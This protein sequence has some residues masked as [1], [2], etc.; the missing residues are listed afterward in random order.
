MKDVH[1]KLIQDS[2]AKGGIQQEEA[3]AQ[4]YDL[5]VKERLFVYYVWN[6]ALCAAEIWTLRKVDAK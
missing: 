4:A 2:Q 5:N 3:F 6:I 1:V